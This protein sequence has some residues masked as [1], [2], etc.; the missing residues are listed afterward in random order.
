MTMVFVSRDPV[1]KAINGVLANRAD[2]APEALD[3]AT[4]EVVAF[5]NPPKPQ[6]VLSQDLMAQFTAADAAAIQSAI[7]GNVQ[8]WLLWSAMVAQKDPMFVTN[9]RFLAG[10]A[11]LIQVLGQ[12]RMDAIAAALGVTVH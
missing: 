10:W 6:E 8:F 3:D 1:T 5:L 2:C 12:P 11:A 4:P 7:A 9:A